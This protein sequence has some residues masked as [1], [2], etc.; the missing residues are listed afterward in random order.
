M[1]LGDRALMFAIRV[2]WSTTWLINGLMLLPNIRLETL[3]VIWLKSTTT[4]TAPSAEGFETLCPVAGTV[5]VFACQLSRKK[6]W[7]TA[8]DGSVP[9]TIDPPGPVPTPVLI[10][11]LVLPPPPPLFAGSFLQACISMNNTAVS[12]VALVMFPYM[13]C[14]YGRDISIRPLCLLCS[15]PGRPDLS[16]KTIPR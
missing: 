9:I 3:V 15:L 12:N 5:K 8:T 11:V 6:P 7:V 2:G 14:C 10:G 13:P 4:V 1:I 16:P